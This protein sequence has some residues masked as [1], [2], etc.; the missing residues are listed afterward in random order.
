MMPA[1]RSSTAGASPGWY[2]LYIRSSNGRENSSGSTRVTWWP[3]RA[4]AATAKRA[5][6]MPMRS[7]RTVPRMTGMF[8][9]MRSPERGDESTSLALDLTGG[10]TLVRLAVVA[11]PHRG[12]HRQDPRQHQPGQ[13]EE[14]PAADAG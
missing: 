7:R 8:K 10:V 11:Q 13:H 1:R 9:G 6:R 12:R 4:R 3:R 14:E 2:S 5:T